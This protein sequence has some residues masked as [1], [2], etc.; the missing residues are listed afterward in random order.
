MR[1]KQ[2]NFGH[3]RHEK[4][5]WGLIGLLDSR[6]DVN[7]RN[8]LT[9]QKAAIYRFCAHVSS[10]VCVSVWPQ[11]SVN[12]MDNKTCGLKKKIMMET[13]YFWCFSQTWK[14]FSIV[15]LSC[16]LFHSI[17]KRQEVHGPW[18]SAW[19]LQLVWHWQFSVDLY[20]KFTAVD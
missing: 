15:L 2:A 18:P 7:S 12:F 13:G 14:S 5:N 6:N 1:Y 9:R 8:L 11:F 16:K 19:Q 4:C 10:R 17:Y 20:Q 3:A